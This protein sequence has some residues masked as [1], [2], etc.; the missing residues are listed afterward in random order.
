MAMGTRKWSSSRVR[1]MPQPIGSTAEMRLS[2]LS[3]NKLECFILAVS[4]RAGS[5]LLLLPLATFTA[6]CKTLE[7]GGSDATISGGTV[8]TGDPAVGTIVELTR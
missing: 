4:R 6:G 3:L 2:M 5:I 8:A 7:S 1:L